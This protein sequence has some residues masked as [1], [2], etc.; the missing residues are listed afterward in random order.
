MDQLDQTGLQEFIPACAHWFPLDRFKALA[1]FEQSSFFSAASRDTNG[2]PITIN[3][4]EARLAGLDP[5]VPGVLESMPHGR[6]EFVLEVSQEPHAFVIRKQI[7]TS[8]NPLERPVVLAYYYIANNKIMQA[9]SAHQV[10]HA[11][12]QRCTF[13]LQQGFSRLQQ[14]LEPLT[15]H[16]KLLQ[17]RQQQ[18]QQ[19]QQGQKKRER[20]AG[21]EADAGPGALQRVKLE[22]GNGQAPGPGAVAAGADEVGAGSAAVNAAAAAAAAATRKAVYDITVDVNSPSLGTLRAPLAAP[23]PEVM[24]AA[25]ATMGVS[26]GGGPGGVLVRRH[27]T[28]ADRER[29]NKLDRI[30]AH[31]FAS[32]QRLKYT[33]LPPEYLQ[34]LHAQ[35]QGIPVGPPPQQQQEQQQP[36]GTSGGAGPAQQPPAAAAAAAH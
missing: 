2:Q 11:R 13:A 23:L 10:T 7:R 15:R 27:L 26:G 21:Q 33:A 22:N 18:Q 17:Q 8:A 36:P 31:Q 12:L 28:D 14:D 4:T 25:A 30:L 29:W 16:Q 19:Q 6:P 5:A 3:N 24:A 32:L 34:R 20:E 35:M 9:P 1:Y